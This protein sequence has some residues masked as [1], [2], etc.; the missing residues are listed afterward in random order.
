[1]ECYQD[2]NCCQEEF[3]IYACIEQ[4]ITPPEMS[5]DEKTEKFGLSSERSKYVTKQG[6]L[7]K[8]DMKKQ[9]WAVLQKVRNSVPSA[10]RLSVLGDD[11]PLLDDGYL[12]IEPEGPHDCP[13]EEDH[14]C[15]NKGG[16]P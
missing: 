10:I 8:S 15:H 16:G 1:M 4:W 7:A 9:I 6:F 3:W 14:R 12:R 5:I 13:Q 11:P 2:S